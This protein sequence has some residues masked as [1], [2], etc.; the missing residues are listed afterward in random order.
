MKISNLNLQKTKIVCTIGPS[1]ES[2]EIIK[3]LLNAGMNVARINLSH[4][5]NKDHKKIIS[6]LREASNSLNKSLPILADLPGPKYRVGII[7][8]NFLNT[9]KNDLLSFECDESTDTTD[10]KIWPSGLHNDVQIGAILLVDDGAVELEVT[11]IQKT[12]IITTRFFF[13]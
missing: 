3:D 10:I 13:L 2:I 1:S 4:G 11:E 7:P 5:E 9:N 6:N 12:K 8:N